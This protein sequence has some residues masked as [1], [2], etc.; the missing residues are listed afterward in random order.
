MMQMEK[1]LQITLKHLLPTLHYLEGRVL[2]QPS[3]CLLL[4]SALYFLFILKRILSQE[5]LP[6]LPLY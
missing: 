6:L 2:L 5:H 4:V 1:D 3:Q